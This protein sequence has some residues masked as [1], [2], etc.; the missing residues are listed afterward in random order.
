MRLPYANYVVLLSLWCIVPGFSEFVVERISNHPHDDDD[1]DD[2]V[3]SS[4]HPLDQLFIKL[5]CCVT[6]IVLQVYTVDVQVINAVFN[7]YTGRVPLFASPGKYVDE[8]A[9]D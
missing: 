2:V 4:D 3:K 9:R 8:Y 6:L 5:S 1:D 7:H